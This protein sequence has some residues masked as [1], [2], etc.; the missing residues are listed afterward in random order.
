MQVYVCY[1]CYYNY[2]DV[3]ETVVKIVDDEVKALVWREEVD[4]TDTDF[5]SY[6]AMTVE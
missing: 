4:D 5:R 1:Q 6:I 2:C 3:F